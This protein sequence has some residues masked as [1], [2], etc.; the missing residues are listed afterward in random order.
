MEQKS[1]NE[2]GRRFSDI[3]VLMHEAIAKSA[4]LT[5][6]DHKYLGMLLQSGP[7][8]AGEFSRLTGLTTGAITGVVDRLEK[9]KLVKRVFDKTDRRKVTI[10]AHE[11]EALKVLGDTS[12]ELKKR[13]QALFAT[14]ND[15][16][17]QLIERFMQSA[18][19]VMA[20]FTKDL[21]I[22]R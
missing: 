17:T 8:T 2:L 15:Q 13:M 5:G 16:E 12:A 11:Q 6:T 4:G 18:I 7:V 19:E 10:V 1:I 3:T 20:T 22:A 21:L 14:Y 9:R